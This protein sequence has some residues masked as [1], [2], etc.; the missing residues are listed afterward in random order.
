MSCII[1]KGSHPHGENYPPK[2]AYMVNLQ[3]ITSLNLFVFIMITIF[4]ACIDEKNS[5]TIVCNETTL[6]TPDTSH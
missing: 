4:I 5:P 2:N 1:S 6:P 3:F